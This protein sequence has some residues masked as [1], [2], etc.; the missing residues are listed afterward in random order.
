LTTY[1]IAYAGPRNRYTVA[2]NAGPIIVHNCGYGVGHVK[3]QAMMKLKGNELEETYAKYIIDTYRSTY[4][5]IPYLW[6]EVDKVVKLLAD[7]ITPEPFGPNGVVVPIEDGLMM[8]NGIAI[9]YPNIRRIINDESGKEEIVYDERKGR[10][11]VKT[12]LYGGKCVENIMQSLARTIIG[13][14]LL[15]IRQRYHV[16]LTV[17]DSI[18]CVVKEDEAQEAADFIEETMR[19]TPPWAVGLP[20]DCEYK[21]KQTYG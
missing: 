16:A 8:P 14:Q 11:A 5:Y 15:T 21:I 2:T 19:Q 12:K 10:G 18:V 6:K 1:D 7:G 17:H 3:F 9:Q 13:T 20:L 4:P